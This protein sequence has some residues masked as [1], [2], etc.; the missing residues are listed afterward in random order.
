MD[1]ID[2]I[3][4]LGLIYNFER[5]IIHTLLIVA[6]VFFIIDWITTKKSKR[7]ANRR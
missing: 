5:G 4:I 6:A 1:W 2:C 7:Q 3:T